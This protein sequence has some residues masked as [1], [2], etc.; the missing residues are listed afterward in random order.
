MI[1]EETPIR[2]SPRMRGQVSKEFTSSKL[3]T[4]ES[5]IQIILDNSP[6]H[7][8]TTNIPK[9]HN[10]ECRV[11]VNENLNDTSI[12]QPSTSSSKNEIVPEQVYPNTSLVPYKLTW[13][14]GFLE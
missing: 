13:F 12:G 11:E 6:P 7:P 2:R 1:P 5:P 4:K 9:N 8:E 10:E 3:S 14:I